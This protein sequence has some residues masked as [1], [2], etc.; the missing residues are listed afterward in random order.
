[1]RDLER[2]RDDAKRDERVARQRLDKFLLRQ[3]K[4]WSQGTRWTVRHLAWIRS[5]TFEHEAQQRVLASYLLALDQASSRVDELTKDIERLVE[6]WALGPL[7][8]ALQALRGVKLVT[9]VTLAAEIGD[10]A[11][12]ARPSQLMAYVGLVPSEHSSGGR[13]KQAGITKTG[14]KHVRRILV[15]AAWSYRF[16]SRLSKTIEARRRK[17]STSVRAIAEKA[18]RRLSRRFERM[19]QNGKLATL[20]VTAVARELVGFVWAIAREKNFTAP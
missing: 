2:T 14:N 12:F 18:E 1:M 13:R 20:S 10:F 16:R 5:Q 4:F 19:Q 3:S 7:V 11:R 6:K 15:E 8:T 17:V 9:A